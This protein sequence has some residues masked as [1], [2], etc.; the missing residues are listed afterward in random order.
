MLYCIIYVFWKFYSILYNTVTDKPDRYNTVTDKPDKYNTVSHS[1]AEFSKYCKCLHFDLY[2]KCKRLHVKLRI[3]TT[4]SMVHTESTCHL[5]TCGVGWQR[6][7]LTM[8]D[9][10]II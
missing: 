6:E 3:N 9:N 1:A 7:K 2:M 4:S 5:I 10:Q 8:S